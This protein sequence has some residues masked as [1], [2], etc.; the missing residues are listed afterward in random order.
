VGRWRL[1][2]CGLLGVVAFGCGGGD[3]A[4][5]PAAGPVYP[6]RAAEPATA[7]QPSE[8]PAGSVVEVGGRPEGVVYDAETGL[9][10]VGIT[11]PPQLALVDGRDGRVVRRVPLPAAPRHLQ[12][13]APGGPVLVPAEE[14]DQLVE[15]DLPGGQTRATA[16]GDQPHD[17][18]A[19]GDRYYVADEFSSSVTAVEDG[20]VVGESTVDAQPGGIVATGD[21]VALISV[22]AFTIELFDPRTL[23]GEGSR[24]AGLGP[25][26]AVADGDGRIYITDTRGNAVIV[27]A[28]RP[29]LKWVGRLELPGSPYGI[30][31]DEA[32]RRVWVTLTGRNEVVGLQ[33]GDQPSEL[34]RLPTVRQPNTVA[35]DPESGR[36]FVASRSDGTLQLIDP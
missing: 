15:V 11:E 26:H 6:P 25:T 2:L 5:E 30:T 27:Y 23:A 8:E 34:Q 9:V 33:G 28:T 31:V 1:I 20:R 3:D 17:A 21:K 4:A 19:L 10:A 35:V 12:L 24:N 13:A 29:R 7:P 14:S 22:L 16:V 18:A 32:D 36:V